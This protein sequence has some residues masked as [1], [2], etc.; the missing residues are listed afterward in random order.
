MHVK[1]APIKGLN[2]RCS[3]VLS[4]KSVPLKRRNTEHVTTSQ[5]VSARSATGKEVGGRP[6]KMWR[7][8]LFFSLC[9]A[10]QPANGYVED[11]YCGEHNCYECE[12]KGRGGNWLLVLLQYGSSPAFSP[13]AVDLLVGQTGVEG[14]H[15]H[16]L[17]HLSTATWSACHLHKPIH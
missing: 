3:V 17:C 14:H 11:Y 13:V 6:S 10:F 7:F 15:H 16:R 8:L 4:W 2:K 9:F 1:V 5:S 12:Y